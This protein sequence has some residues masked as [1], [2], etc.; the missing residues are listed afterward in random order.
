VTRDAW[1]I[2]NWSIK[3][4]A[5]CGEKEVMQRARFICTHQFVELH[6]DALDAASST[7]RAPH[8]APSAKLS[9]HSL[10]SSLHNAWVMP[11]RRRVATLLSP[12][13]HG[14][15][16]LLFA[17]FDDE[18]LQPASQAVMVSGWNA[19]D[20]R[21]IAACTYQP[22][23]F[24]GSDQCINEWSANT[25]IWLLQS[26]VTT[27]LHPTICLGGGG[28]GGTRGVRGGERGEG[29]GGGLWF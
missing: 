15:E 4:A 24:A 21:R 27:I 23:R 29:G 11:Y 18:L 6:A 7:T 9:L 25:D 26:T 13:K 12:A 3:L 8:C 19:S 28:G 22:I 16:Q 10:N 17:E 20:A 1:E 2:G 5:G 14:G